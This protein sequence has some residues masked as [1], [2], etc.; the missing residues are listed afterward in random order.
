MSVFMTSGENNET[1]LDRMYSTEPLFARLLSLLIWVVHFALYDGILFNRL[2]MM[3]NCDNYDGGGNERSLNVWSANVFFWCASTAFAVLCV[4]WFV[5]L[6]FF[7][8]SI[9]AIFL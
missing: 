4:G 1:N 8:F 2:L 9:F 6:G 7:C 5:N 3:G